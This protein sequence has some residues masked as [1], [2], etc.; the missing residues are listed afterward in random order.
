MPRAAGPAV[1]VLL[2]VRDAAATLAAC[3]RSVARQ[4][5]VDFECVVVDDGSRDDSAEIGDQWARRDP[6]F[7]VVRRER[8]GL[9]AALEIGIEACRGA[10]IARMDA[11][12]L[13]HRMRLALQESALAADAALCAIGTH[14]RLFPRRD[15]RP[16]RLAYEAW[17][18]GIGSADDVRREAM[19]E[20][21]VAHPTWMIRAEALRACRYR[22]V[23]WPEDYDLLLR[24]LASGR[25]LGVVPRRLLAW[26]D[27]PERLS[28]TDA[29]YG[30]DR[31]VQAKAHFL[32]S[33]LLAGRDAYVLWGYGATGR[34]LA[35]ALF[36]MGRAPIAIVELHPGRLGNRIL[37]APV[38]APAAL[39]RWRGVP[40]LVSVA[41]STPRT[42]IRAALLA[43]G[44]A[45]ERDFVCVA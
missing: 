11:D 42:E 36:G 41:G 37:G 18:N 33:G 9:V 12:D 40:L 17:L 19:V 14:V 30:L 34:S 4:T 23:P 13:M 27:H 7:R 16:G 24:L 15:L 39:S 26:R 5:L 38:V 31:F 43:R 45:E 44:Y 10:L 32:C 6:R 35:R 3:L 29:R 1:S 28:R 8:R 22:D 21:P 2:P 20:C 25:R